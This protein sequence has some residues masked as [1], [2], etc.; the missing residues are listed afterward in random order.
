MSIPVRNTTSFRSRGMALALVFVL[1]HTHCGRA[2][3][4]AG[5]TE[6]DVLVYGATPGGFCAAIA[7]AREGAAVILLEPTRHVGG[8][9]TGGLSFSDSNQTVRSTLMGLFDE[10]HRRIEADYNARGIELPYKVSEKNQAT[11]TYEPHVAARITQQMLEEAKVHVLKERV[12]TSVTKEGSRITSLSTSRGAFTAKVFVDATYEGDLLAA[13]GVSW[14]IGREGRSE[15]GESLAGQQYP[16]RKLNVDGLDAAGH[17]LPLTTTTDAGPDDA[18]DKNVMT[19]SFRLCLTTD[20]ANRV[21]M[22]EP[23]HY[24]PAPV[25]RSRWCPI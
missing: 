18:G 11:W 1:T 15:F 20:P 5:P 19:Y 8:L 7:A 12:L 13:A 3:D 25:N 16:K 17:P 23:D 14:T 9:N 21:P 4:V 10:W 2:A 24:D 22:P 6:C